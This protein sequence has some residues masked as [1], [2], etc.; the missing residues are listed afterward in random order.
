M[1]CTHSDTLLIIVQKC[2]FARALSISH[3][4]SQLYNGLVFSR[5]PFPPA[6]SIWYALKPEWYGVL[7]HQSFSTL[8]CCSLEIHIGSLLAEAK[9]LPAI[10]LV[11]HHIS[12]LRRGRLRESGGQ[13]LRNRGK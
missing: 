3:C 10:S 2:Y 11:V 12:V 5:L 4:A 8:S 13:I 7:R 1:L 6:F 9:A